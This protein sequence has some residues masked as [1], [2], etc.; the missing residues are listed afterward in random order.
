MSSVLL[1]SVGFSVFLLC[2]FAVMLSDVV[3]IM[4]VASMCHSDGLGIHCV[5][6]SSSLIKYGFSYQVCNSS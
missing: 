1:A 2:M 4:L 6:S 3:V 5:F